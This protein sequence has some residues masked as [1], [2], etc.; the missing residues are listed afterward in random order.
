MALSRCRSGAGFGFGR[1][2]GSGGRG[3]LCSQLHCSGIDGGSGDAGGRR[4][5][6][7]GGLS[8]LHHC[9]GFVLPQ[10]SE[11]RPRGV[12]LAAQQPVVLWL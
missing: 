1:D 10:L 2:G 11:Q 4:R 7:G 3:S 5:G 9:R 6:R 12:G 8:P